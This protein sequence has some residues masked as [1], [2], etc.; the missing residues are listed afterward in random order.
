M[1]PICTV[2]HKPWDSAERDPMGLTNL[3]AAR[4]VREAKLPAASAGGSHLAVS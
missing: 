1:S 4:G 2:A 3:L